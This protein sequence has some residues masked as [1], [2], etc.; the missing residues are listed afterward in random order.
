LAASSPE[1]RAYVCAELKRYLANPGFVDQ[2]SGHLP[3]DPA[4]QGRLS[5]LLE[6]LRVIANMALT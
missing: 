6:R 5:L 4:S 1:L 2:L 3:S